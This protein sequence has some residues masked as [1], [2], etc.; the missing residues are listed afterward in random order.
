VFWNRKK[1]QP[2][3]LL[4]PE[5]QPT[6]PLASSITLP[7]ADPVAQSQIP[8]EEQMQMPLKKSRF[9][10][11]YGIKRRFSNTSLV[12]EAL[13]YWRNM[14]TVLALMTSV[15]LVV[16]TF[17]TISSN[18]G[19][20]PDKVPLIYK[21]A[22]AS[23]ELIDKEVLLPVPIFL[24]ALLILLTNFSSSVYRFDRRLSFMIN[25]AIILF[26]VLGLI[27]FYQILSLTLIY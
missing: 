17:L 22:S 19:K 15:T 7:G 13:P 25:G 3:Q 16:L 27:A 12:L 9:E 10:W 23:W 21:Q 18:F 20:L 2:V 14:N 6:D 26:N 5:E 1:Q 8:A 24:G 4:T 11:F